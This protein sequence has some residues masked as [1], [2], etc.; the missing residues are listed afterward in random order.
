[1][2]SCGPVLLLVTVLTAALAHS[3]TATAAPL[4][5][6]PTAIIAADFPD[7]D[8]LRVGSAFFAYSTTST[9]G[10]VPVAGAPS[11][12]GPWTM[13]GD[14]L[15]A[16]PDWADREHGFWAPDVSRREDGR[17]LMY[18]T[19]RSAATTRMCVGAALADGP[20]GPFRPVGAGPLVCDAAEGGDIDP[21]SFVDGDGRRY[22]LYKS[23][24]NA[25]DP[26]KPSIIWLQQV[27]PDG[28]AFVGPRR[29]LIRND[30]PDEDGVIEAPVLVKRP[31]RYVLFFAGGA[32]TGN[33]YSTRY[34]TSTSLAEPFAKAHPPLMTTETLGGAVQGPGGADVLGDDIFFHGWQGRARWTYRADLGWADDRPVVRGSL[35]RYEAEGGALNNAR[36][37][38]GAAGASQGA[39]VAGLDHED[40]WVDVRVFAPTAGDYTARVGYA[41]GYGDARHLVT[42]N[43]GT[44]FVLDYPAHGWDVWREAPATLRLARGWNT[45]RFQ[46]RDRWAELDY[47]DIA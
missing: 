33:G 29:E 8:V 17:Y 45:L 4:A 27:R 21:A 24:G 25:L 40:S 30:H 14:A 12:A 10:T 34:A 1:M 7:P 18:F 47:V 35:A 3:G 44:Q 22:L 15:P 46:H 31:S 39:V 6:P 37:R 26:R 23:D 16:K 11:A 9:A 20:L 19:A 5:V 41:A 38:E 28:I 2:R 43:G 32:Y 36:I 13:R 42:V